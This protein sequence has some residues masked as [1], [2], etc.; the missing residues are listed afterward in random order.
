MSSGTTRSRDRSWAIFDKEGK[1]HFLD[2]RLKAQT[3]WVQFLAPPTASWMSWAEPT[4]APQFSHLRN[5]SKST[6]LTGLLSGLKRLYQPSAVVRREQGQSLGYQHSGLCPWARSL[7]PLYQFGAGEEEAPQT[8]LKPGLGGEDH[9]VTAESWCHLSCTLWAFQSPQL[10]PTL[11][12]EAR[13]RH[14]PRTLDLAEGP[15]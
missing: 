3:A 10:P 2:H 7:H 6:N 14:M 5:G 1:A 9:R 11:D 4:K 8:T 12:P 15:K 13:P